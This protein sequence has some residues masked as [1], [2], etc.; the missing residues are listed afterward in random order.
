MMIR[1][2]C[3]EHPPAGAALIRDRF[4]TAAEADMFV[5]ID[6]AD[7]DTQVG[8][9]RELICQYP[10]LRIAIGH[11]GMAAVPGWQDQI[12]LARFRGA[13]TRLLFP[14]TGQSDRSDLH[15]V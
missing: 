7:G 14:C 6:M 4:M 10:Q 11:F 12:R 3:P 2:V 8:F 5:A 9:L 13:L 1:K 15:P